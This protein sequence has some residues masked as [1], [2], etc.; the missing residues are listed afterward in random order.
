MP[1]RRSGR[2]RRRFPAVEEQLRVA[3]AEYGSAL[4]QLVRDNQDI[5]L[6][7][8]E[9]TEDDGIDL[10][11][12][13]RVHYRKNH[14]ELTPAPAGAVGDYPEALENLHEWMKAHQDLGREP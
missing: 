12:W 5:S 11:L 8:P 13:L 2:S 6:L 7:R 1:P 9:E 14:P 3:R 4:E 10:P